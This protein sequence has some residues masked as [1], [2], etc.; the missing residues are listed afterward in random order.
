M[1]VLAKYT[2]CEKNTFTVI[3]IIMWLWGGTEDTH[4]G[5]AKNT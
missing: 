5:E 3:I 4:G 2:E 1:F